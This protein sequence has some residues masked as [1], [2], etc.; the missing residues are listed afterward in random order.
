MDDLCT[1]CGHSGQV[2]YKHRLEDY[3]PLPG[4]MEATANMAKLSVFL[5]RKLEA[6]AK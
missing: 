2:K 3:L 5:A 4:P 6:E 1:T